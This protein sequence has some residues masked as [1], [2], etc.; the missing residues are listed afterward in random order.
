MSNNHLVEQ[1]KAYDKNVK[2]YD[3][4]FVSQD[5]QLLNVLAGK[6]AQDEYLNNSE[7]KHLFGQQV[8]KIINTE[9]KDREK[10]I[11]FNVA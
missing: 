6:N 2:E 10:D 3:S 11:R 1:I 5:N 7:L 9:V 4:H 8:R